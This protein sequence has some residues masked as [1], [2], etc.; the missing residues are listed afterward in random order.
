MIVA[1]VILMSAMLTAGIVEMTKTT[2]A[3]LTEDARGTAPVDMAVEAPA[4]MPRALPVSTAP[5]AERACAEAAWPYRPETC[6]RPEG[7]PPRRPVRMIE[8]QRPASPARMP[9]RVSVG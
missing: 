6:S 7:A 2:A 3:H 1:R 4:A 5:A 9:G 8:E